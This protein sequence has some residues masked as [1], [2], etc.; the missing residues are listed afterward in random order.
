M[1]TP[2]AK[3]VIRITRIP[4]ED[5]VPSWQACAVCDCCGD[6]IDAIAPTQWDAVKRVCDMIGIP[7]KPAH[8]HLI[9]TK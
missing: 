8:Y 5:T 6:T 4:N 1:A 7:N 9:E 2:I 3:Q